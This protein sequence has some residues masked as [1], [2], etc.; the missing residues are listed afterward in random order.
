[1]GRSLWRCRNRDC[2]VPHGA[3]LGRV[4][5]EGGLVL[6]PTVERFSIYLDSQRAIVVCPAC[7]EE[8]EFRGTSIISNSGATS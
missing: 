6:D 4:T 2:P 5:G 7:H 1:M 8:R 3:A